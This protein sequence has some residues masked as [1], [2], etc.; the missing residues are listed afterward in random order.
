M[1]RAAPTKIAC[2]LCHERR[3]KCDRTSYSPCTQCQIAR[4]PCE[5]IASR[6]G[7]HR[8]LP[9]P[10]VPRPAP[11]S[12][13]ITAS[14]ATEACATNAVARSE[15]ESQ[16]K[17][18]EIPSLLPTRVGEKIPYMVDSS[19]INYLIREFGHPSRLLT[20]AGSQSIEEYLHEALT[21]R[22]DQTTVHSIKS[23][24]FGLIDR[25]RDQGAFDVPAE[26]IRAALLETFFQ[27]S[28]SYFPIL[29]RSDFTKR[30]NEG[31][32]SHLL[33]NA[34][35]MVATIYCAD[36]LV[37]E[38]GFDSRFTASLTFYHRAKDIYDA[39]YET[40]VIT[41]IQST[42]L[43]SHWWSGPLEQKDPW[44]WLGI[45]ISRLIYYSKKYACLHSRDRKVWR[46]LWWIIYVCSKIQHEQISN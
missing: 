30:A 33:L 45:A 44:Y 39:G 9:L 42:F 22:L 8:K 12:Q 25:L 27:T 32:A 14:Q 34:I 40:D 21:G 20:D 35:F 10:D 5:L 6:R 37:T 31:P 2:G 15:E 13:F 28:F 26:G 3:V 24:R 11:S 41:V 43:L 29:D 7:R 36:S 18:T 46:R 17:Q 4:I 1:P 38:A 19:N 16:H 23:R